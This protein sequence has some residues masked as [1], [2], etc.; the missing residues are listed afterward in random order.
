MSGPRAVFR[1]RVCGPGPPAQA[2]RPAVAVADRREAMARHGGDVPR[3]GEDAEEAVL[4]EAGAD[5]ELADGRSP[6]EWEPPD[7]DPKH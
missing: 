2:P 4:L 6:M 7:P 3:G 1:L 5:A